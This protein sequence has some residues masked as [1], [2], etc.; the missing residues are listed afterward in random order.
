M[1]FCGSS[2]RLGVIMPSELKKPEPVAWIWKYANGEEEVVFVDLSKHQLDPAEV[3]VPSGVTPLHTAAQLEQYAADRVR[4]AEEAI[5]DEYAS[6]LQSDLE[7]GVRSIN[8]RYARNFN[9][10]YPLLAGFMGWLN[11]RTLKE[12]TK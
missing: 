1:M 10:S 9:Q 7:H 6:R 2:L 12:Q 11:D 5:A 4:E 8:E 3:D